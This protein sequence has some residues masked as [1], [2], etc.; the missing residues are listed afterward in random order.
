MTLREEIGKGEFFLYFPPFLVNYTLLNAPSRPS[1]PSVGGSADQHRLD[2]D[3]GIVKINGQGNL[4][5]CLFSPSSA[6]QK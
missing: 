6:Q 4:L 1:V 3:D 5:V 2:E